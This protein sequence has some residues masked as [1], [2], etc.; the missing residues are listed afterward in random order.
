MVYQG[1][2]A[3]VIESSGRN[4]LLKLLIPFVVKPLLEPFSQV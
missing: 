3:K 2:V 1:L 4:I